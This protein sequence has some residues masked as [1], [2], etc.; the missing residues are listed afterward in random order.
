MNLEVL[1]LCKRHETSYTELIEQCS[2]AMFYHSLKYRDI[3]KKTLSP[4][5]LDHYFIIVR[6]KEVIAALPAFICDGN[7][8]RF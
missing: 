1:K 3:L 4:N 2:W 5:A 8:E 6:D 7:M